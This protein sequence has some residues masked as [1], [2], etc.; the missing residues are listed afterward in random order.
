MRNI[1]LTLSYD[2]TN[3]HGWQVQPNAP[4]VQETLQNAVKLIFNDSNGI[5][6]CSR[7]DAGV[8][9]NM[10]CCNFKTESPM[11]CEKIRSALNANL[12]NDIA[13][14]DVSE[15]ALDFHSRYDCIGKEY[16]Y[17]IWNSDVINPFENKYTLQYK[18]KLD[19]DLLNEACKAYIGKHDYIGFCSAGSSV[20]DTVREVYSAQVTRNGELV[21]F[22]V[23]AN[24]FL[25]NMVRIMT[26]TLLY[27]AQGKIQKEELPLIIDSKDRM[28][29]GI[30]VAPQGLFLNKV[31]YG[32]K[33]N[34]GK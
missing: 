5:I 14:K 1:L 22:K 23:S 29:A 17:R 9:A 16:V 31:N 13:V 33:V 26:G 6:G 30:T 15:V 28:R 12:P 34:Y 21:E 20:K 4:T 8:H 3:Y 19:A 2:G 24:G 18:Y 11:P 7:T 25:Y 10:Y 32:E 27:V